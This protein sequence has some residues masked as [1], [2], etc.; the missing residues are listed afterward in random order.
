MLII[1]FLLRN[2]NLIGLIFNI[3]GVVILFFYAPPIPEGDY[4]ELESAPS[5]EE[6]ERIFKKNWRLSRMGLTLILIGF[7]V[8]VFAEVIG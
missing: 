7:V 1:Q 8:Q 2:A 5:K 3:M 4:I 6:K